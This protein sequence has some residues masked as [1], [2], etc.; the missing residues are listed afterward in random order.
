MSE[1]LVDWRA[2]RLADARAEQP[3]RLVRCAC[4]GAL[5]VDVRFPQ[6]AIR[7]HQRTTSHA[8]WRGR[9]GL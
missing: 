2:P 3:T 1:L 4:G 6:A 5:R 8:A 7:S 9:V